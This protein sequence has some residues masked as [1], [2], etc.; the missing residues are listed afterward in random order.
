MPWPSLFRRSRRA[1][2]TST[3]RSS[4]RMSAKRRAFKRPMRLHFYRTL[5]LYE[6]S[7]IPKQRA[8]RRIRDTYNASLSI[9]Q[10]AGN[11]I[12]H[13]LGGRRKLPF[14]PVPA[15]V[16]DAALLNVGQ[17]L[18]ESLADWLPATELAI[19]E[20][21]EESGKQVQSLD[22]AW[23]LVRRQ[24]GMWSS[25]IGAISYPVFLM[26]AVMAVLYMIASM[27][28]PTVGANGLRGM[29]LI[30]TF[31]ISSAEFIY[32][33]WPIAI[34]TPIILMILVFASLGRWKSHGRIMADRLPPWSFY[35]RIHGALFL[36]SYAVLLKGNVP[37][38]RALSVLS[39]S[40]SPWLASRIHAGMY[41]VRQGFNIGAAF[42]S[43]G[44]EFPDREAI[45]VL[46]NIGSLTGEEAFDALI[47]YAEDWLEDTSG[48]I[49][50][51]A[52]R[53]SALSRTWILIWVALLGTTVL[54][55][56][57]QSFK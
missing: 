29:S 3:R 26:A 1:R 33:Y 2:S 52:R 13:R 31:V 7:G 24:A 20:A 9:W 17:P 36:F 51:L 14:R 32:Q 8:L 28:L 30:S 15:I 55:I 35:R 54:E 50:R 48:Y 44:H 56:I 40:A 45:P 57:Q 42:R 43:S 47:Q 25:V 27:L 5:F 39:R 49:E 11:W 4:F 22:M 34:V 10:R 41:G 16:A 19:L 23:R 38:P 46:E 21:G 53:F 12:Y 18:H 6:R 37:I